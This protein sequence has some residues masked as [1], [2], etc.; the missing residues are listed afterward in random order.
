MGRLF[1]L[2]AALLRC[3]S[4]VSY[5]LELDNHRE[6]RDCTENQ[7]FNVRGRRPMPSDRRWRWRRLLL[8]RGI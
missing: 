6:H 7:G 1:Y 4:V 8:S 5:L 2:V 3:V